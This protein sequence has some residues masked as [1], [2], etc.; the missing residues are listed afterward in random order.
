MIRIVRFSCLFAQKVVFFAFGRHKAILVFLVFLVFIVQCEGKAIGS[1]SYSSFVGLHNGVVLG[2]FFDGRGNHLGSDGID[3]GKVYLAKKG[4]SRVIKKALKNR[5]SEK[6]ALAKASSEELPGIDVLDE[7]LMVLSR[8]VA[9]GGLREESSLVMYDGTVVYGKK[10]TIPRI[11]NRE[12]VAESE[13]PAL[14]KGSFDSDVL[15]LIHFHPTT[16]QVADG[17]A[18]SHSA[19]D[20]SEVDRNA[21]KRFDTNIIV[22]SLGQASINRV[23]G[24]INQ[25]T[26]GIAVFN[27]YGYLKVS[28]SKKALEKIINKLK[29]GT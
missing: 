7:S 23:S 15:A 22:G 13:V 5:D 26:L 10:G 8:A 21:F 11:V 16:V 17:L 18:F 9:N 1:V 3:D 6:I 28:L 29:Q 4:Q 12:Q 2:D 27:K 19:L 25:K 20:P 24:T 14:P